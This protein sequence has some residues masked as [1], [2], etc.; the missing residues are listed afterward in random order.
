MPGDAP[1]LAPAI[2]VEIVDE[3]TGSAQGDQEYLRV[4]RFHLVARNGGAASVSERFSYDAI[5]RWNADAV[6]IIPHFV[7]DGVR[8]I[9]LRSSV[10][11]PFALRG[12]PFIEP[13]S[14]PE[15]AIHGDLWEIPAGLIEEAE[16]SPQGLYACA[17]RETAEEVGLQVTAAN[18]HRLG[19]PIFPSAGI[20]AEVI[21][22]F[23]CEVDPESRR[24]PEGD[25][26]PLERDA[27]II[28]VPLAHALRWCDDGLLPDAKTELSV[29]R[30]AALLQ[31]Q[32]RQQ[33][34]GGIP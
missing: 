16:R 33:R 9:I 19:G 29:R 1:P 23:E 4:R 12:E 27:K 20:I 15:G 17:I 11:P 24:A 26:S 28:E 32:Q 34:K 25:G 5:E 10:R 7:R 13:E 22:L 18:L 3:Y 6:A 14:F 31:R 2:R 30:L 8:F 21:Y